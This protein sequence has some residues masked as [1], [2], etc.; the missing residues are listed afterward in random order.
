VKDL[1]REMKCPMQKKK[2]N[3]HKNKE[4]KGR[5]EE[6]THRTMT[7]MHS[8]QNTTITF[9]VESCSCSVGVDCTTNKRCKDW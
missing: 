7:L 4:K 5:R 2:T 3:G 9:S 6:D 8:T 1:Y